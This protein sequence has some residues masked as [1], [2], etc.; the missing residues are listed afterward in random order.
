MRIFVLKMRFAV[1]GA[2]S[3]W[4]EEVFNWLHCIFIT[5]TNGRLKYFDCYS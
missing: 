1:E 3:S 2:T 4:M 5:F